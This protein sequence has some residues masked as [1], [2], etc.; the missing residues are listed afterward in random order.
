MGMVKLPIVLFEL[1]TFA[2]VPS[3]VTV[4]VFTSPFSS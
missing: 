4:A 2:D 1:S 3:K